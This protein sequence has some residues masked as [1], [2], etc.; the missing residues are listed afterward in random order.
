MGR[1]SDEDRANAVALLRAGGYPDTRG[2]LTRTSNQVGIPARTI[3][4]WFNEE[5]N[6]PPPAMVD[7][8]RRELREIIKD[9]IYEVFYRMPDKRGDA[10]YG[11][12]VTA[13]AILVDKLQLLE[14]KPTER[15][16]I[17]DHSERA[18]R[19]NELLDTARDRRAGRAD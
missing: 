1:Y 5:Q 8:K 10:S 17:V 14:D 16:E 2:A 3:S 6:P 15:T 19:I 12:L 13:A 11:S 18:K 7:E 9:E 4:R